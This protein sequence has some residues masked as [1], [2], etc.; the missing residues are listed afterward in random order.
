MNDDAG[1][2]ARLILI[3]G[4]EV[5]QQVVE[6]HGADGDEGKNFEVDAHAE[7]CGEGVLRRAAEE[8]GARVDRFM[9]ASKEK[10]REGRNRSWKANLRAEE[11]GF[12]S[13]ISALE[14]AGSVA[15]I[16]GEAERAEKF[17]G[18]GRFPAV[19]VEVVSIGW[20]SCSR[21]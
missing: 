4:V 12:Q 13:R 17:N 15:E 21:T 10:M 3:C 9:G 16:G 18:A 19:E 14:R 7:S 5:R 1:G 20:T 6:L 11:I 8:A 2:D